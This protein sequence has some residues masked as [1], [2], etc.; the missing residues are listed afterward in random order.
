MSRRVILVLRVVGVI[1]V[2]ATLSAQIVMLPRLA[3]SLAA[4]YPEVA[5]LRVPMLVFSVVSLVPIQVAAV[6]SA[7]LARDLERVREFGTR[8]SRAAT[9]LGAMALSLATSAV[10]GLAMLVWAGVETT[11]FGMQ[12]GIALALMMFS[13]ACLAAAGFVWRG[14]MHIPRRP[15]AD[16]RVAA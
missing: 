9:W 6:L 1:A 8:E 4:A 11:E 15:R 12:P 16:Q 5:H 14:R 7:V 10:L 13:G 3:S 2:V